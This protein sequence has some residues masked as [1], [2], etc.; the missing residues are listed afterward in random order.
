MDVALIISMGAIL[1]SGATVFYSM[2]RIK[3]IEAR[4]MK[5]YNEFNRLYLE[6]VVLVGAEDGKE[7]FRRTFCL[8]LKSCL[9]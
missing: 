5:L 7:L 8:W 9:R 2:Q 4:L 1:V 6:N 3:K